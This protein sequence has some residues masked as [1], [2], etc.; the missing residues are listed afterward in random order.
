[1]ISIFQLRL[2]FHQEQEKDE[3]D[4]TSAEERE[5]MGFTGRSPWAQSSPLQRSCWRRYPGSHHFL[6]CF[7]L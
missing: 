7:N 3:R 5:S 2:R 6:P 1:V 4:E